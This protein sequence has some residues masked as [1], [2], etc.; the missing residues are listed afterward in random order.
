[1]TDRTVVTMT[2]IAELARV[3]RPTVSNWRRRHDNFPKPAK[4][5]GSAPLFDAEKIARWLDSRPVDDDHTYGQVF[6]DS[7]RVR[8]MVRLSGAIGGDDILRLSVALVSLRAHAGTPL[9]STSDTIAALAGRVERDHPELAGMFIPDLTNTPTFID[10]LAVTVDELTRSVGPAAAIDEFISAADRMDSALRS[11]MTPTPVADLI[12]YLVG[13]VTG[14]TVCDPAAGVG[15]LLLRVLDGHAAGRVT[16]A[17][18]HPTWC[19][20][21]RHRLS[22]HG[23]QAEIRWG[24]STADWPGGRSDV[25]VLDPPYISG[26]FTDRK[27]AERGAGPL[28]WAMFS[29]RHLAPGGRA[30][31]VVPTWT[32]T[33]EPAARQRLLDAKVLASVIQLPRRAHSFLTGTELAVLELTAPGEASDDVVLCNADRL[34]GADE[35]WPA[36]AAKLVRAPAPDRAEV[37]RRMPLTTQVGTLL[38]AHRLTEERTSVDHVAEAIG[39]VQLVRDLFPDQVTARWPGVAQAREQVR[40]VPLTAIATLRGGHRISRDDITDVDL[41]I[42]GT[43]V[44]G[45]EE[46]RGER[47]MRTRWIDNLALAKYESAQPTEPGDVIALAEGGLAA[48]VDQIGGHLVLAP[49][50]VVRLRPKHPDRPAPPMRPTLLAKLLTSPRNVG[51]ESGSL[52]RRVDL[53]RLELPVLTEDEVVTLDDYFADLERRRSDLAVKMN[54]LARLDDALSAGIADGVLAVAAVPDVPRTRVDEF[55]NEQ[56]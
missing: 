37:C 35:A 47:A 22:A 45:P 50:Q 36:T 44:I 3:R 28:D 8:A 56:D 41:G 27:A 40:L 12:A 15:S 54:A 25:I 29:A 17:D 18:S 53:R 7:L 1:M 2:D 34:A 10:Q 24:D 11:T 31:V 52:V 21:L 26:E 55:E 23:V 42:G 46:L 14:R 20:I 32:L 9:P 30:Y 13:D 16:V 43:A 38:P 6:R 51:R 33:R 4:D 39:A 5:N 48:A 19:R 49:A